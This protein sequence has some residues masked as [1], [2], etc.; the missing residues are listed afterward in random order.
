[1]LDGGTLAIRSREAVLEEPTAKVHGV[2]PGPRSSICL[3]SLQSPIV[4][5]REA[6]AKRAT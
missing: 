5:A 2:A 1:M 3:P 6:L 4:Q